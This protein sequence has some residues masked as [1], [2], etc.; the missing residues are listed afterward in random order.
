MTIVCALPFLV[1]AYQLDVL[2]FLLI[3]IIVVVSFRLLALK[4]V[5]ARVILFI[6]AARL[7]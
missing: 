1:A 7:K 6:E 3:N 2:I 5:A 4:L